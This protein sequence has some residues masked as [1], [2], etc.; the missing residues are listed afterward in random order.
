MDAEKPPD[1][2]PSWVADIIAKL[3]ALPHAVA[4]A[5]LAARRKESDTKSSGPVAEMIKAYDELPE[6]IR[7]MRPPDQHRAVLKKLGYDPQRR[8]PFGYGIQTFK[9]KVLKL[10]R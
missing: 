9:V 1:R 10:R 3:D 6:R 7:T 4:E 2:P 5:V 8:P